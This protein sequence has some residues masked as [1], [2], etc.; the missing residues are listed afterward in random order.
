MTSDAF[1]QTV[2]DQASDTEAM[3][4]AVKKLKESQD[5]QALPSLI[6][7]FGFN[8]PTVGEAALAAV[9]EFGSV[10]VVPVLENV[11]G[12]DYGA[13]AYSV[14]ALA[15]LGDARAL[16]FLLEAVR[17]DFAPSVRRAAVRGLG[18][19]A[20]SLAGEQPQQVLTQLSQSLS[21]GDW[22]IRYASICALSDLAAVGDPT[23]KAAAH[24]LLQQ[25]TRDSE[26]LIQLRASVALQHPN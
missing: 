15:R 2:L 21:D 17:S 5:P 3:L 7:A 4:A 16:D 9:L 10:A 13:R 6:R 19:M 18:R 14:R 12:Y 24:N 1:Y 20:A 26:P 23:L 8:N 22:A 11:D 25:A